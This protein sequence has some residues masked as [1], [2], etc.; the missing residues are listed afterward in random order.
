MVTA[1]SVKANIQSIIAK[2]NDTTGR[3]D[4]NVDS[5][6][7][8]LIAGF[9]TGSGGITPTGTKT[10][11]DN[12]TY[13]VTEYATAVV[14][15][16]IPT[17]GM[18]I[19]SF[20]LSSAITGANQVTELISNDPYI[21]EHCNDERFAIVLIPTTLTAAETGRVHWI[22]HGNRNIGSST[23]LRYGVSYYSSSGSAINVIQTN[24]KLNGK[25]Y[26]VS[27]RIDS[28][29]TLSIYTATGRNIPAGEYI[30]VLGLFG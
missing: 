6:V 23:V 4:S 1:D 28:T 18:V 11:T 30:A 17:Q 13:D 27:L 15:V 25:G 24:G 2:A 8:A 20:T 22:Y 5:A 19:R 21:A 3:T 16:P 14:N 29:G 7:D 9:G 26:T 10:I 12:G